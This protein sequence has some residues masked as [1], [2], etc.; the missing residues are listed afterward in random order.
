MGA[1]PDNVTSSK[2]AI[3]ALLTAAEIAA[4][5][6][7]HADRREEQ[8]I[9]LE[10]EVVHSTL[11]WPVWPGLVRNDASSAGSKVHNFA[12]DSCAESVADARSQAATAP[13]HGPCVT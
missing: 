8:G 5:R 6:R 10:L 9:N 11:L 4:A 12:L 3:S 7:D 2:Y 1:H 13:I